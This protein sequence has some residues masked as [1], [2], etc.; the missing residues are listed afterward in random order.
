MT[1]LPQFETEDFR[2][3][4]EL[5]G[6]NVVLTLSGSADSPLAL[7]SLS[8]VVGAIHLEALRLKAPVVTVDLRNLEFMGSSNFK[9]FVNWLASLNEL[10]ENERFR[11]RFL[12]NPQRHWQRRSINALAAFGGSLVEVRT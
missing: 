8:T 12:S 2:A 6:Q 7:E 1:A 3:T 10:G 4:S 9:V 5:E 11:L